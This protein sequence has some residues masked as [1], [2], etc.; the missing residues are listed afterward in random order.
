MKKLIQNNIPPEHIVVKDLVSCP[1]WC[2]L[3]VVDGIH[4]GKK[5][6]LTHS[7]GIY[8]FSGSRKRRNL[9]GF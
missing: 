7:G 5:Y 6:L 4:K 3:E 8:F 2:G 9:L 1:L